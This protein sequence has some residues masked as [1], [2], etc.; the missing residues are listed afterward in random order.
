MSESYTGSHTMFEALS[1]FVLLLSKNSH[2]TSHVA[3]QV[4][5]QF[6]A[7]V[8]PDTMH[9]KY[10]VCQGVESLVQDTKLY[11]YMVLHRNQNLYSSKLHSLIRHIINTKLLLIINDGPS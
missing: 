10:R 11:M 2:G 3:I 1:N 6:I 9:T 4:K 7:S 5:V 8:M